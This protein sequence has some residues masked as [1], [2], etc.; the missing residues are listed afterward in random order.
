MNKH[1]Y[2]QELISRLLDEDKTL[3]QTEEEE[4]QAH[5]AECE[6]CSAMYRAFSALSESLSGELDEAPEALRENVM[7]EIRREQLWK[8]NHRRIPWSGVAAAA[9]I[10]ALVIGFAPR[11][12]ALG[13]TE[14]SALTAQMAAGAMYAS[15]DEGSE[16]SMEMPEAEYEAPLANAESRKDAG[17]DGETEYVTMDTEAAAA[18]ENAIPDEEDENHYVIF[19]AEISEDGELTEEESA[20][21][22]GEYEA[23]LSMSS[24][25]FCLDGRESDVD[26][27]ALPLS[28][29]YLI[30]T[31]SGVLEIYRY[32]NELFYFD[33]MSGV[34]CEAGC[35]ENDLIRFLAG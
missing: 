15:Y 12:T 21:L 4:L 13:R 28:P 25:L 8:H 9:A 33:P 23:E 22:A 27:D 5:L 32:R 24:L 14:E 35:S 31:D 11:L 34:L 29:V 30:N 17:S 6:E 26:P 2:Y 7:A 10:L 18:A 3:T 16:D 20:L 19:G 1:T